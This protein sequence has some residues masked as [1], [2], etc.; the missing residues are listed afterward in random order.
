MSGTGKLGW[1]LAGIGAL[2]AVATIYQVFFQTPPAVLSP[3]KPDVVD[4][5]S[6]KGPSETKDPPAEILQNPAPEASED[7]NYISVAV[8]TGAMVKK[9][10]TVSVIIVP[11]TALQDIQV[12]AWVFRDKKVVSYANKK[13]A[14]T[15]PSAGLTTQ[16]L[17]GADAGNNLLICISYRVDGKKHTHLELRDFSSSMIETSFTGEPPHKI[18]PLKLID[19]TY[20][21]ETK[22]S[23]DW[24]MSLLTKG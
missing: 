4:P 13:A 3:R 21:C 24:A 16:L 17:R 10:Q 23:S 1:V 9:I 15:P 18:E 11:S 2:G 20:D 14:Y 6:S 19:A 12:A 8:I 22:S 7:E 5:R